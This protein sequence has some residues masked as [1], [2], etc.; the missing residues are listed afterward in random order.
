MRTTLGFIGVGAM[1]AG[2][3][4]NLARKSGCTVLAADLDMGN[5]HALAGD[6]VVASSIEEIARS[7]DIVFLSLP[8]IAQVEAVCTGPGGL[9]ANVDVKAKALHTIVDMSTS[10]VARTRTLAQRLQERGIALVDAPVARSREAAQKGTLLITVGATDTQFAALQPHLA[11]MGSDVLHCGPTGTGQVVKIMNNMV[12]IN[13]VH[14]L[15]EACAIAER[16]GVSKDLL[17]QALGLGSA[18][19]FALQ[20]TGSQYLA[21]DVFPEKMFS[22]AYAHKDLQLALALARNVGLADELTECTAQQL[23]KSM[24]RGYA[25]NYYPVMYRV[26]AGKGENP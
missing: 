12:L 2:M 22:A 25:Q 18:A 15:A 16:S 3:C 8:A 9:L 19:S 4:R 6:G 26:I 11:C 5:V 1:G 20:L 10:D 24:D 21:K 7:A 13:T 14:A 17:T 23:R